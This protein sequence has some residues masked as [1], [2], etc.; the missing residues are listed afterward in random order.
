MERTAA[1]LYR[2]SCC[3]HCVL[4][5]LF[6]INGGLAISTHRI[7]ANRCSAS[8]EVIAS[9]CT[10]AAFSNDFRSCRVTTAQM[11]SGVAGPLLDVFYVNSRLT[12]QEILGTNA[13]TQRLGHIIKVS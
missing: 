2:C 13:M 5:H 4:V 1:L 9:R 3:S 11:L 6:C 12:R 7:S 10:K 8:S